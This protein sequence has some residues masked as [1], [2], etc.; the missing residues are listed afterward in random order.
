MPEERKTTPAQM[1]GIPLPMKASL[2]CMQIER[3]QASER[4][5]KGPP[6]CT[7]EE[8]WPMQ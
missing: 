5:F 2:D 7:V 3:P 8:K 6:L 4:N 1:Q